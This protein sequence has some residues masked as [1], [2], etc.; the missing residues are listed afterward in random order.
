MKNLFIMGNPDCGKTAVIIGLALK[1][2]E[3]G[4]KVGYFKPVDNGRKTATGKVP[5]GDAVLMKDV[6]GIEALLGLI[7]PTRTGPSYLGVY[8]QDYSLQQIKS[9]FNEISGDYDV[10]LVEGAIFPY[11]LSSVGMDSVSL[12]REFDSR[13]MN[14]VKVEN[15]F[16]LDLAIM[17]NNYVGCRQAQT[18]GTI[19]ANVPRAL[20]AKVEGLFR[21]ALADAGYKTLG[22]IPNRSEL[23]SP[24]VMEYQETLGGELLVGHENMDRLVEDVVVGAMTMDSALTYLRRAAN[25]A[26]ILGGDRA[27]LA[28]AALETHTSVLVL[29][30]GLYPDVKVLARAGEKG[31]PVI[32]TYQDT[33][34]V[35]EMLSQVHRHIKPNDKSGIAIARENFEQ[36]CDFNTILEILGL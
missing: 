19:F 6:L 1:L 15:D 13:V 27:D 20:L 24:T 11:A 18:A 9:A 17:Y 12:A 31:V 33:Y 28:L 3:A 2:K 4:Y 34:T 16:S 21:P 23:S 10:M 30:G 14:V 5:G 36:Y 35:I 29:T 25:K 26:V 22:V 32:L 7:N 8:E